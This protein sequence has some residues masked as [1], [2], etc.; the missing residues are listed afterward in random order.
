[1]DPQ[2]CHNSYFDQIWVI[3]F[4]TSAMLL[5]MDTKFLL[6]EEQF[7]FQSKLNE[8]AKRQPQHNSNNC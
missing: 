3:Y 4:Q 5:L 6:D 2:H 8:V 7:F 1:M